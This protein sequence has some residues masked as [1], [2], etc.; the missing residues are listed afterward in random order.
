M[1]QL[2]F[3]R[4]FPKKYPISETF[5][6]ERILTGLI[7]NGFDVPEKYLADNPYLNRNLVGNIA[8]KIHTARSVGAAKRKVGDKIHFTVNPR[9]EDSYQFAPVV[10]ITRVDVMEVICRKI[11]QGTEEFDVLLNGELLG[12]ACVN[13]GIVTRI[14]PELE[15]F[16][17]NDGFTKKELFFKWFNDSGI[18][19]LISWTD[20]WYFA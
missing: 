6:Q 1:A 20:H 4:Y 8:P 9:T 14:N 10:T 5:F 7:N 13:G 2:G 11:K 15:A 3:S 16:V 18:Y 19:E 12:L 17:K